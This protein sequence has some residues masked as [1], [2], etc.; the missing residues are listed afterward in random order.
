MDVDWRTYQAGISR[1]WNMR[2]S[3]ESEASEHQSAHA[4]WRLMTSYIYYV[5]HFQ[6]AFAVGGD[7]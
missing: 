1:V 3:F 2:E 6:T 5:E 7:S 4:R